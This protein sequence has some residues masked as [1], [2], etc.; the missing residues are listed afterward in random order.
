[1]KKYLGKNLLYLR[2]L[3]GWQQA[4]IQDRLNIKPT[5]WSMYENGKSQPNLDTLIHISKY[6]EVSETDLIHK[7]LSADAQLIAKMEASKK[8]KNAQVNAQESAQ[9]NPNKLNKYPSAYNSQTPIKQFL[10]ED[11]TPFT[12]E[13][14]IAAFIAEMQRNEARN[15]KRIAQ[16]EGK[17]NA[18]SKKKDK[19]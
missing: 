10:N 15:A 9:G 16:L 4:E 11:K 7:D 13:E 2:Q 17:I 18:L 19:K 5:T 3:K 1:M 6:F 12:A 8:H 14:R